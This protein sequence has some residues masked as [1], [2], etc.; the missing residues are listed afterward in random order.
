MSGPR[1][2]AML[3]LQQ[4]LANRVVWAKMRTKPWWPSQI[5]DLETAKSQYHHASG[6]GLVGF[7]PV[8]V[9]FLGDNKYGWIK[10]EGGF[11][12]FKR[13]NTN[14]HNT[15]T[16]KNFMAGVKQARDL[17]NG[18]GGGDIGGG[19]IGGG[20]S[21]GAAGGGGVGGGTGQQ[22]GQEQESNEGTG[23]GSSSDSGGR[24]DGH[25]GGRVGERCGGAGAKND[26]K[27]PAASSSSSS[28]GD[29]EEGGEAKDVDASNTAKRHHAE[30]PDRG[31]AGASGLTSALVGKTAEEEA[32]VAAL[33]PEDDNW[34]FVSTAGEEEQDGDEQVRVWT[35]HS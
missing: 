22:Q 14:E 24:G 1:Y 17:M 21:G 19:D 25:L 18:R 7:T 20:S 15:G 23:C 9:H 6:S 34:K 27:R 35:I 31:K 2:E 5:V 4:S 29:H 10:G 33:T 8:C 13:I 32:A 30:G 12:D 11:V 3:A 28:D 16:S 26:R